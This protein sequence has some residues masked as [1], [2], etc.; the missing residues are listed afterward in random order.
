MVLARGGDFICIGMLQ[1]TNRL[2][3][4]CFLNWAPPTRFPQMALHLRLGPTTPQPWRAPHDSS[5]SGGTVECES[6]H[7]LELPPSILTAAFVL[8]SDGTGQNASTMCTSCTATRCPGPH[9][10]HST[11]SPLLCLRL[12][13]L[14]HRRLHQYRWSLRMAPAAPVGATGIISP[15]LALA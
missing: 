15:I 1:I 8:V 14:F 2:K 7:F 9:L 12:E 13:P 10:L 4:F 5:Y 6:P 3:P 11:P